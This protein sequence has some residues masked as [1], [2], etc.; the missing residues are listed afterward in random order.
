MCS[1]SPAA[2]KGILSENIYTPLPLI[3]YSFSSPPNPAP[4][5]ATLTVLGANTHRAKW[6]PKLRG[7]QTLVSWG[8][9]D[10]LT[11]PGERNV[12]F[13]GIMFFHPEG[14]QDVGADP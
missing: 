9:Q 6:T 12:V 7:N 13:S 1:F 2:P 11:D 14:V 3:W 5:W 10:A 8:A 4:H